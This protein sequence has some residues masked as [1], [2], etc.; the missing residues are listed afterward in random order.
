[1]DEQQKVSEPNPTDNGKK[2]DDNTVDYLTAIKELKE[3]TVEL[4]KYEQLR[5]ENKKLIEAVVNGQQI[6]QGQSQ[7]RTNDDIIKEMRNTQLTNLDFWIDTLEYRDN[8]LKSGKPDPFLPIGHKTAPTQ[9]DI[10]CANRVARVVKE[11]IDYAKGDPQLF[12]SRLQS[13]IRG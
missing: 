11:C 13:E 12:T 4:S 3:N 7:A 6:E 1:M 10:E 5:E 2:V 8:C 9:N